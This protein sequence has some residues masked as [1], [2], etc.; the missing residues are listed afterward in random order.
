VGAGCTMKEVFLRLGGDGFIPPDYAPLGWIPGSI[1]GAVRMNAGASGAEIG[2]LVREVRGLLPGGKPYVAAGRDIAWSYR[3]TDLPPELVITSVLFTLGNGDS[4]QFLRRYEEHGVWR[5][6]KQPPGRSAGSVFRKAGATS[7]G[8]LIEGCGMKST[9]VG[10]C[11]ISERHANFIVADGQASETDFAQ[12]VKMVRHRVLQQTGVN[13]ATEVIFVN[14]VTACEVAGCLA[15]PVV[16]VLKGGPSKER[17][18]SLVSGGAVAAGLRLAGLSVYEID[19][20]TAGLPEIPKDTDVVFPVLH[21]TFGEDGTL[22]TL[23][24]TAGWPYVAS[25]PCASRTAMIKSE[26]KR[27]LVENGIPTAAFSVVDSVDSDIPQALTF[28]VI[29]KPNSQGSSVGMSKLE[30]PDPQKWREALECALAVDDEALVEEFVE[31]VEITVGILQGEALPVFEIVPP[32]G[33]IF[34][35]DAKY[36]H[37]N[38]ETQYLCP[39]P[40]VSREAQELACEYALRFYRAIGARDMLRVDFIVDAHDTPWCLE[41][42]S[43][44]GFTPSSLL[45]KA[46]AVSG[47]AFPELCGRLVRGALQRGMSNAQL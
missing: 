14:P 1:G 3:A 26:S 15:P 19:V 22:Q 35:Y 36:D 29:V 12:L 8:R 5:R 23:L 39:P 27:V 33:R 31:G 7:A 45:P 4:E 13:L 16:A 10:G 37:T 18:V 6:E 42:N 28:P 20:R 43:I 11:R 47:I 34:D 17:D 25:G 44:P 21:G 46:A 32:G 40:H 30:S 2:R 24:E 41:G 38:G 9:V